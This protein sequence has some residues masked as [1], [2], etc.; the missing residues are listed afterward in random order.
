MLT[1]A[2]RPPGRRQHAVDD[3]A[4]ILSGV[5]DGIGALD[6]REKLLA[7]GLESL[8]VAGTGQHDAAGLAAAV[9]ELEGYELVGAEVGALDFEEPAR[10]PLPTRPSRFAK[11]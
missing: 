10:W 2:V 3:R 11:Y 6:R 1:R 9:L 5:G 4:K 8:F 7:G